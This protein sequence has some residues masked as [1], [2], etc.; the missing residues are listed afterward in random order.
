MDTK[1]LIA[2]I[3]KMRAFHGNVAL[4]L[5]VP[6]PMSTI[7]TAAIEACGVT[8]RVSPWLAPGKSYLM[9]SVDAAEILR[10]PLIGGD[11]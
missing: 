1:E 4:D 11:E 3:A 10:A 5:L 7:E 9:P 8:V 6:R 2:A